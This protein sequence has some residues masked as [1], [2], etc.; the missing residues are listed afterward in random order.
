MLYTFLSKMQALFYILIF[1]HNF[2]YTAKLLKSKLI[3][4]TYFPAFSKIENS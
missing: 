3:I 1:S 2:I 4:F